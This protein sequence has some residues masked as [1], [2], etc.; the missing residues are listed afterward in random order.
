MNRSM[1]TKIKENTGL[2][3]I[4]LT[5]V[6]FISLASF[7]APAISTPDAQGYFTQ[8]RLIAREGTTHIEPASIVQYLGPH[9]YP[10]EQQEYFTTFPPGYPLLLAGVYLVSGYRGAI[11]LDILLASLCLLLLYRLSSRIISRMSALIIML[12]FMFNPVF[13]EHALFADSHIPVLFFLLSGL[14]LYYKFKDNGSLFYAFL[15]GLF[16]GC[17]PSF[18]YADSLISAG[19]MFYI[20]LYTVKQKHSI[21]QFLTILT[22]FLLPVLLLLIHNYSAFGSLFRTAYG[23]PESQP[24]FGINYLLM[25]TGEY[26]SKLMD[27]GAGII[28]LPGLAGLL[29]FSIRRDTREHGLL[30]S[31]LIVP[32]T[33]LYMSYCWPPDPQSMRFLLPTLPFYVMTGVGLFDTLEITGKLIRNTILTVILGITLITGIP[34]SLDR[35]HRLNLNNR[36]LSGITKSV[37]EN[38]KPGSLVIAPEGINQQLDLIGDWKLADPNILHTS[39]NPS[40]SGPI[41]SIPSY[42]RCR[43]EDANLKYVKFR[44]LLGKNVH[45]VFAYDVWNWAGDT[46][47]VFIIGYDDQLDYFRRNIPGNF[48]IT[49]ECRL[50]LMPYLTNDTTQVINPNPFAFPRYRTTAIYDFYIDGKPLIISKWTRKGKTDN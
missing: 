25:Y 11:F 12:I 13:N 8:A 42:M 20:L 4:I 41:A 1:L 14:V 27:E 40:V 23:I 26:I 7:Y 16:I 35:L 39:L 24:V 37:R 45:N 34:D 29:Y 22:G 6:H 43:N 48:K 30:A 10:N 36:I 47:N 9:W 28:F 32:V 49:E 5:V 31:L 46:G 17:L 19:F 2:L 44:F 18:R 21:K 50:E 3:V 38:I 15:S 33:L